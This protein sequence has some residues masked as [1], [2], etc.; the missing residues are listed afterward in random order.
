[1][2]TKRK[3]LN[4][5]DENKKKNN[6]DLSKKKLVEGEKP[7]NKRNSNGKRFEIEILWFDEFFYSF[8]FY[9]KEQE[10]EWARQES[11]RIKQ[12]EEEEAAKKAAL[13]QHPLPEADQNRYDLPPEVCLVNS[14]NLSKEGLWF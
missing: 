11:L 12:Q 4:K 5:N 10:E 3:S 2:K 8:F 9:L 6:E 7:L 13:Q 1:M 14:T